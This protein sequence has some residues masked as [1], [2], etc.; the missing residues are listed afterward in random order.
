MTI[1]EQSGRFQIYNDSIAIHKDF[2]PGHVYILDFDSKGIPYLRKGGS[3]QLPGKLY[4][5]SEDFRTQVLTTL[6]CK[7]AKNNVG[8]LLEGYKGMGK[9]I[10]AKLLA[11]ESNLPIIMIVN[12]IQKDFEFVSF[13]NAIS[14]NHVLFIDEF[15]KIFERVDSKD[16]PYHSQE[17]FLSMLD[18]AVSTSF[19]RLTIL[20]TN[21]EIGDKFINRPS[22]I[23][24]YK[25]YAFLDEGIYRRIIDDLLINKEYQADLE[26][27]LDLPSSTIDLLT[28]IIEEVNIQNRPYSEW[29][30]IFN[31]KP[32][33]VVYSKYKRN[34]DGTYSW[35]E[36]VE[37]NKEVSV[38][39]VGFEKL[40]GYKGKLRSNDG[41][42]IHYDV[43][44]YVY[45]DGKKEDVE[46]DEETDDKLIRT[47]VKQITHYKLVK[48]LPM[49]VTTSAL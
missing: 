3:L 11:M 39:G 4:D 23:R 41:K 32:R 16:D 24:Y 13:L 17:V 10:D 40:V 43:E 15:E 12:K 9:S 14:Q 31:N 1:I 33:K 2:K 7:S 22:R 27:H 21:D 8:V 25:K 34:A 44:E 19:K 49:S 47:R 26:E 46:D 28:T 42:N 18:G 5:N 30:E 48:G 35:I 6:Q 38:E 20:T 29:K 36:D 37:T 45:P